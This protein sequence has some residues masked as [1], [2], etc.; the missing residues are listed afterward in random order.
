VAASKCKFRDSVILYYVKMDA[1]YRLPLPYR[2]CPY[3]NVC[4]LDVV[5]V[6]HT[7]RERDACISYVAIA[8]VDHVGEES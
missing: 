3:V 7:E 5:A 1:Y 4:T 8:S 2:E 6:F